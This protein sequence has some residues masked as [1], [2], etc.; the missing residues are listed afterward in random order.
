MKQVKQTFPSITSPTTTYKNRVKQNETKHSSGF[1]QAKPALCTDNQ[2]LEKPA[3]LTRR[4]KPN[5]TRI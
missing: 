5:E 1:L 3:I 4:N 2:P